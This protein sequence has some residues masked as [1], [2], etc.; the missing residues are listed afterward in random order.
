MRGKI[1][2]M[3]RDKAF[4]DYIL[5]DVLSGLHGITSRPMFGGYGFYLRGKIFA[6]IADGKLYFKTGE[7]NRRDF[8]ERGSQPFVY[9]AKGISIE[10][11]YYELPEDLYENKEELA[12]W[13]EKSAGQ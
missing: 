6:I 2:K 5:M 7:G 12:E 3:A 4:H 13:I 9:S 10:M 8:L 1:R 11:K